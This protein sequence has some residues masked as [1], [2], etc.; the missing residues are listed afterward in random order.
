MLR[1]Y[2]TTSDNPYSP[3]ED[4]TKWYQFDVGKGYNSSALL[5]RL[6]GNGYDG[7]AE[8]YEDELV[9]SSIDEMIE[10]FPNIPFVK[11]YG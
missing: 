2:V 1:A 4:F 8:S 7:Y 9:N 6:V 3:V 5:A 10:N 11:V